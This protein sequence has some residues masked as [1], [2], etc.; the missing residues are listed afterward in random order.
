MEEGSPDCHWS[1]EWQRGLGAQFLNAAIAL[2]NL[3]VKRMHVF[4]A[5]QNS[6][7]FRFGRLYDKRNLPEIIVY[8][9]ERG[10][11][12]AYPW[13]VLMPVG[14]IS[15]PEV[16]DRYTTIVRSNEQ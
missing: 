10:S 8:Q 15:R 7:V 2:G 16:V 1:D 11:T 5:A 6:V 14:G 3:G 9:Y 13:G 4:L 12:P